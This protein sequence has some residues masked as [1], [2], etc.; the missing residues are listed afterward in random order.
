MYEIFPSREENEAIF[1][2]YQS[3]DNYEVVNEGGNKEA[4][5]TYVYFTS[6]GLYYPTNYSNFKKRVC[7]ENYYEW[8]HVA[9]NKK[10][11]GKAKKVIFVRDVYK[12][13]CIQGINGTCDSMEKLCK[14]I[15]NLTRGDHVITVGSSAG[16]YMAIAV[17][18]S[19]DADAIYAL[20]PQVSLEKYNEYHRIKY[21]DRYLFDKNIS[22][23]LNLKSLIESYKGD[24]F[25][26]YPNK[27]SEDIAQYEEIADLR[28]THLHIMAVEYEHHGNPI[29][30]LSLIET[31]SDSIEANRKIFK[32]LEGKNVKRFEYLEKKCGLIKSVS[33]VVG[34][35]IKHYLKK[36]LST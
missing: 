16:G 24:L 29:Y 27:C 36:C 14:L 6:H 1:R 5:Y 9:E 11:K 26:F 34:S 22:P 23:W 20:S 25:Y 15:A 12:N 35:K 28:N 17:G 33:V 2:W 31:L 8:K 30:S 3:E 13:W 7:D 32:E 18:A 10:L 4:N 21:F 19:I